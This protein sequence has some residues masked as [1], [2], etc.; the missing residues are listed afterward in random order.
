VKKRWFFAILILVTILV[1]L[2]IIAVVSIGAVVLWPKLALSP[3]VN[4]IMPKGRV[5]LS[6][7]Q[8]VALIVEAQSSSGISHIDF[9]VNDQPIKTANSDE[10][11]DKEMLTVF[12]WV[13][14]KAGIHKLSVIAYDNRGRA[15]LPDHLLVGVVVYKPPAEILDTLLQVVAESGDFAGEAN[16]GSDEGEGIDAGIPNE[17]ELPEGL[18]S[19]S[20]PPE[21]LNDIQNQLNNAEVGDN[22]FSQD[23]EGQPVDFPPTVTINGRIQGDGEVPILV[24]TAEAVDDIGLDLL[25]TTYKKPGSDPLR[26][27][28]PIPDSLTYSITSREFMD[29]SGLYLVSAQA[30]D[31]SGQ[32]S[33]V[34]FQ[35]FHV[36]I[37]GGG[38]DRGWGEVCLVDS[39]Q[40]F[41]TWEK[42]IFRKFDLKPLMTAVSICRL[43]KDPC[44]TVCDSL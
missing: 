25:I 37:Q 30:V 3:S 43:L 11:T 31:N 44:A 32:S 9:L 20:F 42:S 5:I 36:L 35:D 29:E 17:P 4:I 2:L 12:P 24:Y 33:E 7:G 26:T 18:V 6:S 15:S 19:L 27:T 13:S 22:V 39:R 14:S 34:V 38:Q 1:L 23:W 16:T 10:G 28:V 21:L 40:F 41:L 8:S